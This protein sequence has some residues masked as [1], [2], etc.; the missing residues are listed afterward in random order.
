MP[1]KHPVILYVDDDADD[2]LIIQDIIYDIAPFVQVLTLKNGVEALHYLGS[3]KRSE[4]LPHLIIMDINM[5]LMDGREAAVL[6]RKDH[7]LKT[8][9]LVL[10]TT[11]SNSFDKAFCEEHHIPF[12]TKPLTTQGLRKEIANMLLLI[13]DTVI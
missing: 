13:E 12:V 8:I 10:F 2:Q 3:I 4:E 5:P 11:S 6:M 7:Y 9:P 1:P